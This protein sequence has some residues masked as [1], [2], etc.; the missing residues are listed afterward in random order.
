[1][2]GTVACALTF[3]ALTCLLRK[4]SL[5]L[6]LDVSQSPDAALNRNMRLKLVLVTLN[7]PWSIIPMICSKSH[8]I[9]RNPIHNEYSL[10]S[11]RDTGYFGRTAESMSP[12]TLLQVDCRGRAVGTSD[13][14]D[15][16]QCQT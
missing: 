3:L 13:T 8:R 4:V 1:M 16:C 5:R 6:T 9:H 10:D 7:L 15:T 14:S 11:H 12:N 2:R